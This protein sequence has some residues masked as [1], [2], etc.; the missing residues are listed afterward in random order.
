MVSQRGRKTGF[1]NRSLAALLK[2]VQMKVWV[3][4][5]LEPLPTDPGGRRLLRMGLLSAALAERGHETI[6]FTSSFDHYQKRQRSAG[7]Q[8]LQVAP[9]LTIKVLRARGYH[10]NISMR[11]FLH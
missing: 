1:G 4:R 3:V 9:N 7:D 8:V 10:D 11:R 5:D 2:H 6:W